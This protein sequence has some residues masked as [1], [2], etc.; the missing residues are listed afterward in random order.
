M[1]VGVGIIMKL[2]LIAAVTCLM[3]V[4]PAQAMTYFLTND[5]GVS[6]FQH[7][8]QYSDGNT[9]SVNS[10]QLCPTSVNVDGVQTA[11]GGPSQT[12]FKSGEYRDGLTK[13]CVYNVLGSNRFLRVESTDLCPLT[14]D[15]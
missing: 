6:G 1:V 7:L 2:L 11:P 9:Y 15:F 13:V 14:Y 10:T 12:G 3:H 4:V 8:C 5:L